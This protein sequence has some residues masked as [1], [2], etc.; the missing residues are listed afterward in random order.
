MLQNAGGQWAPVTAFTANSSYTYTSPPSPVQGYSV[1][2]VSGP[3]NIEFLVNNT[4]VY[5]DSISSASTGEV[6]AISTG[7]APET[8]TIIVTSTLGGGSGPGPATDFGINVFLSDPNGG[9][10][11]PNVHRQL[12]TISDGTSN[13]ILLGHAY[14]QTSVYSSTT[15]VPSS[16]QSIFVGGSLATGRNTLGNTAATWLQDGTATTAN[17]WGSPMPEG[18]LMAMADGAVR[19]FPY[20][21]P[22]TN[23]L[24]PDD[25]NPV[26]LPD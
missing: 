10:N 1:W 9:I 21:T 8:I 23:F 4:L 6:A 19:I 15:A 12:D 20:A 24:L 25:G 11:S 16:L 3:C 26:E 13:T 7:Q 2:G 5:N 18:G 22:L 14:V 17:Q